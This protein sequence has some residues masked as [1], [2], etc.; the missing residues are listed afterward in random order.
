MPPSDHVSAI[1]P[2][3]FVVLGQKLKP[4][5]LGHLFWLDQLDCKVVTNLNDLIC[6]ILVCSDDWQKFERTASSL[7]LRLRL[8]VWQWRLS[9]RWRKDKA[10]PLNAIN[11]FN[12]YLEEACTPPDVFT[13]GDNKG[14]I[15]TPWLYHLKTVL[16]SKLGYSRNEALSL[17]M[18][19]AVFD[20]Y[21]QAELNGTIQL[22]SEFDREMQ[23][24][25][26]ENHE[27][28]DKLARETFPNLN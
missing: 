15:G 17:K 21:S 12:K 8:R 6:A 2:A 3:P 1:F 16:Q 25:A 18:R 22:V 4:L 28:L 5:T 10:G 11:L 13:K 14:S 9:W 26:N 23:N 19:E 27:R 20:Y 7:S 24:L